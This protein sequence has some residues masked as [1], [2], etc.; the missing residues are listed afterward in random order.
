[1]V[2]YYRELVINHDGALNTT[3]NRPYFENRCFMSAYS[4]YLPI[5]PPTNPDILTKLL[6]KI[7]LC[8]SYSFLMHNKY[9]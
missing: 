4:N 7:Q 1:M 2:G 6:Q 8:L 9:I 3:E 5:T